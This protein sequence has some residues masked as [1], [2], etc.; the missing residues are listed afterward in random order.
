MDMAPSLI[1]SVNQT[2]H[3]TPVILSGAPQRFVFH[4]RH[5]R[6]VEGS[7]ERVPCHAVSGSSQQSAI[8]APCGLAGFLLHN[9]SWPLPLDAFHS[10]HHKT[11]PKPLVGQ[12]TGRTPYGSMAI[13]KPSGSF[14]CAPITFVR[15][16]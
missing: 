9:R 1:S 11:K 7:R 4:R 16:Q 12:D 14:D 10:S 15:R 5:W 6:E 2:T 3:L 13:D 8:A